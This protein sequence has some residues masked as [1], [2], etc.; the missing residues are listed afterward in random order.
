MRT[1]IPSVILLLVLGFL[2]AQSGC[3][4]DEDPVTPPPP[5]C[6]IT[7]TT[8]GDL[9][10]QQFQTG[11]NIA[12]R[13]TNTTGGNVKIDLFKG[14]TSVGTIAA[15]TENDGFHPWNNCTTFGQDSAEDY[16]IEVSHLSAAGCGDRTNQFKMIDISNCFVTFTMSNPIADLEAGDLFTLTW[17]SGNTTGNVNLELWY[18]PFAQT[19]ELVG[20]IAERLVDSGTYTWEVDSFNRGTSEGYRFKISDD[21]EGQHNCRDRSLPFRITDD[22]NCAIEVMG[23]SSGQVFAV[24]TNVPLSFDFE[25]SSTVVTLRLYT[26]NLQVPGGLITPSFDTQ[27]GTVNYDWTVDLYQHNLPA[28][29]RFNVRAFDV[30]DEY[31]VGISEN[32]TITQ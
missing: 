4:K 16:S 22:V 8:P 25:N 18:E 6:A 28:F 1:A 11:E 30:D 31:C 12:I 21:R 7:M 29:D 32:F 5:A 17:D 20:V 13:W 19:G 14:D 10:G 15:Q 23:I 3:S 9:V 27:N 24:G 26:G 2:L